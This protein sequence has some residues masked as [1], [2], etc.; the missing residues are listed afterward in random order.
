MGPLKIF[1]LFHAPHLPLFIFLSLLLVL[2]LLHLLIFLNLFLLLF[3]R[4]MDYAARPIP[5]P[6]D[7]VYF[8]YRFVPLVYILWHFTRFCLSISCCIITPN[9]FLFFFCRWDCRYFILVANRVFLSCLIW[10]SLSHYVEISFPP[11]LYLLLVSWRQSI[12]RCRIG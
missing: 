2:A 3:I 4:I 11:I 8:H 12:F 10:C 1:F 7:F 9:F 5:M 6:N